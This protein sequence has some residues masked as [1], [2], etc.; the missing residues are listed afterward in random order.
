MTPD[1]AALRALADAATQGPWTT[2]RDSIAAS[3]WVVVD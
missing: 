3:A 1:T 2:Y